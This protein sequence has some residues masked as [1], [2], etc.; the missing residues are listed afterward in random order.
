MP[1]KLCN[2]SAGIL[3][4]L[5]IVSGVLTDSVDLFNPAHGAPVSVYIAGVSL[6]IC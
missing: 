3:L 2:C 1:R 6:L 4:A 5:G